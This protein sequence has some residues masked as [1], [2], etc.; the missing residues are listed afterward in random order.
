MQLYGLQHLH[1]LRDAATATKA[2]VA[3]GPTDLV[4]AFRGTAN[5]QN[6]FH[7]TK[8]SPADLQVLLVCQ[9]M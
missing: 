4:I 3:W 1:V 6:A 9:V 7:D 5:I 8:V 2:L